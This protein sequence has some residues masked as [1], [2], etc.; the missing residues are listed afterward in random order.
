MLAGITAVANPRGGV[1]PAA[2]DPLQADAGDFLDVDPG[3]YERLANQAY[4]QQ[5]YRKAAQYYLAYLHYNSQDFTAIYNLACCYGLMGEAYHAA[6]YLER[7]VRAGFDDIAWAAQDPDFNAVRQDVR[8]AAT[9]DSLTVWLKKAEDPHLTAI[10]LR[11][12]T[13]LKCVIHL[14]V[15]YDS[16]QTYTLV[17]GLHGYGG[18]AEQFINLWDRFEQPDFIYAALQAPYAFPLDEKLG[19]SWHLDFT[20]ELRKVTAQTTGDYVARAVTELKRL[21]PVGEVYLMGFSQGAAYTLI[22]GIRHPDLFAGLIPFGGWLDQ[23]TLD[24]EEIT[25]ANQV[26]IFIAHGKQDQRVKYAAGTTARDVLKTAGYDVTFYAF[27]GGHSVPA[28][29]L[30]AVQQWIKQKE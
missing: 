20:P 30:R 21:Y 1:D 14:P 5:A 22:S 26:R 18:S 7:A 27:D 9:L 4:Q 23:E 15:D 29:G 13:F 2:I 3:E 19:H 12:D 17:L 11:A 10:Y 16:S 25:A 28:E 8:F 6:K 24:E